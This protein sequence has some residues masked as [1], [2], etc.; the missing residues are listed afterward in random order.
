MLN[1]AR[2]QVELFT[3]TAAQVAGVHPKKSPDI[4]EMPD[5]THMV[6]LT[7]IA[8]PRGT[9]QKSRLLPDALRKPR[10]REKDQ[11]H[12]HLPNFPPGPRQIAALMQSGKDECAASG[13]YMI[14]EHPAWSPATPL[15]A[16]ALW[17][18]DPNL[19]S[20]LHSLMES[21]DVARASGR[22]ACSRASEGLPQLRRGQQG[23]PF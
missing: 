4:A 22:G 18:D 17:L 3:P 6:F 14:P 9:G 5:M 12:R 19:I 21:T 10:D 1:L 13:H 16:C 20:P 7:G 23:S 15:S 8:N 2:V 11:G